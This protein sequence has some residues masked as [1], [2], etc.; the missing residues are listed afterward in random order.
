M[1]GWE[2]AA[3]SGTPG[4]VARRLGSAARA[5]VALALLGLGSAALAMAAFS[6]TA[7]AQDAAKG[8]AVFKRCRACH[9]IGPGAQNKSGPQLTGIVGRKAA[10]VAGFDYSDAMK[11][12]AASGLV[13]TDQNLE[14]Y[15]NAPDVFLPQGVMAFSGIKDAGQLKDLIAFLKTQ[16]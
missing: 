11:A 4:L 1:Q 6:A 2:T 13:W 14:A 5:T 9:A 3:G 16:K 7:S 12:R 15:L 8:E 10:A